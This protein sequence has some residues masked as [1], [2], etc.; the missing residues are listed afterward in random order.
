MSE[1]LPAPAEVDAEI[2]ALQLALGASELHGGLCGWLAGGG[3]D[4]ADWLAPVLADDTLPAP[5]AGSALD[6][7]IGRASCRER[8]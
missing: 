2:R 3:A 7:Q 1:S 6:R 8:V 5:V 4:R